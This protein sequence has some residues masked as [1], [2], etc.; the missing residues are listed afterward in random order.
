MNPFLNCLNKWIQCIFDSDFQRA[1]AEES[2]A[3][4][5]VYI[6]VSLYE[7]FLFYKYMKKCVR[8]KLIVCISC[9]ALFFLQI[10]GIF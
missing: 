6:F 3:V 10:L 7:Y 1:L 8:Y 9:I 4:Q 2:L 5:S